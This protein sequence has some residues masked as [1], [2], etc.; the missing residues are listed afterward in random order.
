M[1]NRTIALLLA[2]LA[3]RAPS[4]AQVE[5]RASVAIPSAPTPISV[6]IPTALNAVSFSAPSLNAAPF[7]PPSFAAVPFAAPALSVPAPLPAAAAPVAAA[8]P[9]APAA[10]ASPAAA[11][12]SDP[13]DELAAKAAGAATFDGASVPT[14][15]EIAAL[16]AAARPTSQTVPLLQKEQGGFF[17]AAS[18][19]VLHYTFSGGDLLD[20][21]RESD[22]AFSE[23]GRQKIKA[24][25][26]LAS[27]ADSR[28][29]ASRRFLEALGRRMAAEYSNEEMLRAHI[30]A[31]GF[32]GRRDG[33]E[34]RVMPRNGLG[35][36]E[37]WDMAAG[38]NARH[39]ITHELEPG[40]RYSFFDS[41]PFVVSYLNTVAARNGTSA[42]NTVAARYDAGAATAVAI[43]ADILALKRPKTPLAVLRT[44]NA[45]GYV[46]G[47]GKKLEEMVDWI[48]PGGRLVIQNDPMPGQ[49]ALIIK[50]HGAL[51]RRLLAEG[52]GLE[53]EF[54]SSRGAEHLLDTLIF[55]RPKGAAAPRSSHEARKLWDRYVSAVDKTNER[56][57]FF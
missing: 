32:V 12:G 44:K 37:Y 41:S 11:L 17:A 47:F 51:A 1:K 35:S 19:L 4:S 15:A 49:R 18:D 13:A 16:Y 40:T 39:F 14:E 34:R 43:E 54:A 30:E 9:G 42:L 33:V 29:P 21:I 38:I 2:L 7:A 31:A 10:A 25:E 28:D 45:V 53:F 20:G 55:T 48:A 22:L 24:A 50:E 26:E 23:H 46:P 8:I 56:E 3:V 5:A 27:V 36:G 57:N 52:W 6:A